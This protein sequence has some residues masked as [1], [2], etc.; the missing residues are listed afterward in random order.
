[1]QA[2]THRFAL[3]LFPTPIHR[4]HLPGVPEGVEVY[5]KRDDLTGNQ[6]SGNK[7]GVIESSCRRVNESS[8]GSLGDSWALVYQGDGTGG[9]E[10]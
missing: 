5:I 1:M 8:L 4:W 7:V 2:P 9:L 10:G 6:L 3:G